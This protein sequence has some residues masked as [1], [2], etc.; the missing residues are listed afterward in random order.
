MDE[1][2]VREMLHE[3]FTSLEAL[4]TQSSAIMQF[5]KDKG[6]TNQ[7]ELAPYLERA[8]NASN[9][10]WLAARV[11]MD[12]LLS[13]AMKIPE[14]ETRKEPPKVT[15][16]SQEAN[17]GADRSDAKENKKDPESTEQGPA[18]TKAQEEEG[19]GTAEKNQ[20]Q[21]AQENRAANKNAA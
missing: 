9:V 7:E 12:H 5:L 3:L 16:N 2:V 20:N 21:E 14:K 4:E 15:E 17:A 13:S 19:G 11:R 6:I 10:R 1:N 8:G 18:N